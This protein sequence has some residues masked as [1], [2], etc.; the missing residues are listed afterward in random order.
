MG[1]LH[2]KFANRGR[3]KSTS[4]ST[5]VV[6]EETWSIPRDRAPTA[7]SQTRHYEPPAATPETWPCKPS[8][9]NPIV[10]AMF[11]FVPRSSA[12]V[13]FSKGDRLEILLKCG[14]DWWRAYHLGTKETGYIPKSYVASASSLES[15]EVADLHIAAQIQYPARRTE[16]VINDLTPD[17]GWEISPHTLQLGHQLGEGSFGE[18]WYG[19]WN[20]VVPVAIKRL[21]SGSM[22]R[23][24]FLDEAA[25]MKTLRHKHILAL[26]AVCSLQ[27]PILIVTEYM[28]Y[29]ALL[30]VLRGATY[31]MTSKIYMATQVADGMLYLEGKQLIHR[32]LAARNVLVGESL[33]CKI[34]DF[35]LARLLQSDE[36]DIT[37]DQRFPVK[38]T[39]PEAFLKNCFSIKSDVWSFGILMMEIVTDGAIPYPGMTKRQV[40]DEVPYGYRMKKPPNCPEPFYE[41]AFSCWTHNMDDRP[42]FDHIYDALYNFSVYSERSYD[43]Q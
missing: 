28:P 6:A 16:P 15:Q 43:V 34:S 31:P 1:P 24:Q 21:R 23:E 10:K 20:N 26:H 17:S 7:P 33:I 39:A 19:T 32:D 40:M 9:A 38:W 41:I 14:E 5:G 4:V 18:V 27:E 12:E 13:A 42:S 37:S 29:G 3:R 25:I 35:G 2:A 22:T 8:V 36:Y 30:D 11:D